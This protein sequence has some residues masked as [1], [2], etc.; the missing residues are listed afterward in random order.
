[1][2]KIIP[3]H[4]AVELIDTGLPALGLILDVLD[5]ETLKFYQHYGIFNPFTEDPMR[6]FVPLHVL[7]KI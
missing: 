7:R 5:Q 6:L 2:K 1:V 4:K 3:F